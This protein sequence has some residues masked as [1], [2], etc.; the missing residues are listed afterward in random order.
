MAICVKRAVRDVCVHIETLI[1]GP[2][3][4]VGFVGTVHLP[5]IPEVQS[6]VCVEFEHPTLIH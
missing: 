6:H 4:W 5:N 2:W 3:M 1:P